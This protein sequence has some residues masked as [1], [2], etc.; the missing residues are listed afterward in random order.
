M[1]AIEN[2]PPTAL[3]NGD[4]VDKGNRKEAS[5]QARGIFIGLILAALVW[6]IFPE[7][8]V[9]SVNATYGG[10]DTNYSTPPCG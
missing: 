7:G 9:K 8:A 6:S 4:V 1:T 3:K 10:E 2:R 5:R